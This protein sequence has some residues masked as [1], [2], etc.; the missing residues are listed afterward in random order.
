M[1]ACWQRHIIQRLWI[2]YLYVHEFVLSISLLS[3]D[4]LKY[5]QRGQKGGELKEV[6]TMRVTGSPKLVA[7]CTDHFNQIIGAP[8]FFPTVWGWIKRW[9]DPVTTSK[10]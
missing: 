10:I 3:V 6:E 9:F 1:Q 2:R 4:V 7:F 5:L 8:S